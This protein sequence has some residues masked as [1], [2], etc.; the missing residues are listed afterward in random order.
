[1]CSSTAYPGGA[2]RL[3]ERHLR[4]DD[5][6]VSERLHADVAEP[7]QAVGV[8]R[9]LPCPQQFGVGIDARAQRTTAG[10]G[11]GE[12]DPESGHAQ[13]SRAVCSSC[14]DITPMSPRI[15]ASMP[16]TAADA[17]CTVVTHGMFIATAAERI[18]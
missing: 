2:V 13:R 14:S 18:S 4:L 10:Y 3:E 17:P 8:G 12:T 1:M 15:P 5:R 6:E 7:S 11:V 9:Q 16:C